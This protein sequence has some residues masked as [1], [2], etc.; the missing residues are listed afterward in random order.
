MKL[1]SLFIVTIILLSFSCI[2]SKQT[3]ETSASPTPSAT[4]PAQHEATANNSGVQENK[5]ENSYRLMISFI[6]IGE[7]TDREAKQIF[8]AAL[9]D[10]EKNKMKA[11]GGN[12][13]YETIP[14]GRE[15]EVDF[16]FTLKEM[17]TNDQVQF[18][19]IIR[20]KFT[21]HSLV[22]FAENEPCRHKR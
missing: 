1:F 7:G 12:I 4:G 14:W 3:A 10:W 6:S 2:S 21:G 17:N 22:Q 20:E 9:S 8:D 5:D 18:I 15:G 13:E 11:G 16:C 19:K